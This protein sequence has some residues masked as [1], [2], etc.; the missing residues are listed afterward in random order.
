MWQVLQRCGRR[1]EYRLAAEVSMPG[2]Q[3]LMCLA[4]RVLGLDPIKA[5]EDKAFEDNQGFIVRHP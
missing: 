2:D 5:S 4:L 1:L 3:G